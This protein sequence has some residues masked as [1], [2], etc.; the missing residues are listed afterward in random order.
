MSAPIGQRDIIVRAAADL[1]RQQGYAAT[2]LNEIVARSGAP[3]GSLYHYFPGGK[4]QIGAAA[5][6]MAGDVVTQTLEQL[7]S[8]SASAAELVE[9]YGALL[10]GWM[11]KSGYRA[12]CPI[13]TTLLEVAPDDRATTAAGAAAFAAWSAVIERALLGDGCDPTRA[14]RLAIMAIA[15]IE[16]A[17]LQARV[18]QSATPIDEVSAEIAGLF[19]ASLA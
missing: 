13:A 5:V 14:C 10:G 1:F 3:K 16:G 9:G 6:A 12:G 17:L 2:G 15:A 7:A 4:A 18:Q 8:A 11:T 19:R